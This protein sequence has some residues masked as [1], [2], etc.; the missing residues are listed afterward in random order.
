M[1]YSHTFLG[2]VEACCAGVA[3]EEV[4]LAATGVVGLV[5]G[6]VIVLATGVV[7]VLAT[8]VVGLSVDLAGVVADL[9]TGVLG[10][11]DTAFDLETAGVVDLGVDVFETT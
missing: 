2:E 4:G 9:V 6:V 7:V 10:L 8:G 3:A 1:S 5:D 11:A